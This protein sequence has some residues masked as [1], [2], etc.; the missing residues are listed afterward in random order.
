MPSNYDYK[1]RIGAF[2]RASATIRP[3]TQLGDWFYYT[4]SVEDFDSTT[5]ANT[6]RQLFTLTVPP[7]TVA[8]FRSSTS[9]AASAVIVVFQPVAETDAAPST[10][11]SPG[12]SLRSAAATERVSG[13]FDIVVDASSANSTSLGIHTYAYMDRRGRDD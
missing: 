7:N 1:R 12:I 9:L 6:N 4:T 11:A 2:Y 13:H 3:F 5:A 10:T 8:R